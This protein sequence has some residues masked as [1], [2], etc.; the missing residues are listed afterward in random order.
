MAHDDTP[1]SA[2][3]EERATGATS[4]SSSSSSSSPT[5]P[6]ASSS[7]APSATS[8]TASSTAPTRRRRAW[9]WLGASATAV[10]V[11]V[12]LA[13]ALLAWA[14][15]ST[16]GSAWLV[17]WLPQVSIVAPKGSLLGD[18]SAERLDIT[19]PGALSLRLDSPRW[20]ALGASRGDHGRWLHLKIDTLH[21]DRVTL[22]RGDVTK[23]PASEGSAPPQTLRLPIEIEIRDASIDE[24]RFGPEDAAPVRE[25][26]A[27]LH[28]GDEGGLRH[29]FDDL[30]AAYERGRATGAG[31]IGADPPF[32]I[33]AR[34]VLASLDAAPAW[35]AE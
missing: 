35:Q 30:A 11:V 16:T 15:Q 21:A 12:A 9:R 24:L 3:P 22:R 33:D 31:T 20:H 7:T 18:F 28:F 5:S 23:E 6:A 29:R 26:H 25:L 27:R 8:S 19:L 17:G 4:P 13:I 14:L 1:A 2:A 10:V 32:A 34:A